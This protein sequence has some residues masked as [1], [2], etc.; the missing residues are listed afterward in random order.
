MKLVRALVDIDRAILRK[1]GY[2]VV[3]PTTLLPQWT[4]MI[5]GAASGALASSENDAWFQAGEHFVLGGDIVVAQNDIEIEY[6]K[7]INEH[8]ALIEKY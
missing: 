7:Y 3:A 5:P 8:P 2:R 6:Q 4:L 1:I